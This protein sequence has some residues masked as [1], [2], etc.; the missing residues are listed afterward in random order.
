MLIFNCT[1]A[2]A[3]FF[4][5]IRKGKKTSPMSPTPKVALTEEPILHDHQHWHWMIHVTK[6]GNRNVLLAMDTDSRFCMLFWG[7][8]K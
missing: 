2:A 7:L 5:S 8:R 6:L 3:D 1:K 4:T